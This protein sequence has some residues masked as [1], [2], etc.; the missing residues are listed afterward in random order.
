VV[1][2]RKVSFYEW[3]CPVCGWSFTDENATRVRIRAE[4]HVK[5]RHPLIPVRV[6]VRG[7]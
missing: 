6:E 2:V 7:V 5:T 4:I 1:E 3:T